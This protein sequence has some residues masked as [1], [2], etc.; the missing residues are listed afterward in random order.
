M[1]GMASG[2]SLRFASFV[3]GIIALEKPPGTVFMQ[4]MGHSVAVNWNLI[5]RQFLKHPD[6]LEWL[7]MV[8]DDNLFSPKTL[9]RLLARNVDIVSG[10]YLQRRIPFA[11]L[12]FD[13]IDEQGKIYHRMMKKG[14]QG[15]I[16]VA[17][18]GGGCLLIRRHVLETMSDPWWFYGDNI[19]PDVCNHDINFCRKAS[20]AGFD[21]LVDY[22][23]PIYHLATLP[24]KPYRNKDGTWI[25]KIIQDAERTIIVGS[26][27]HE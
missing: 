11:P 8:E 24:I 10:L 3:S 1:I 19:F 7:F 13:R 5:A 14:D 20:A 9:N 18:C 2:D 21:I 16:K 4:S 17:A 25:S 12:V 6:N 26:A 27:E 15:L 23:E 22:D